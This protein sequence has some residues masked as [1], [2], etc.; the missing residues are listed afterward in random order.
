[1]S[2]SFIQVIRVSQCIFSSIRR[3]DDMSDR[4]RLANC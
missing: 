4:I 2:A 3:P 1:M